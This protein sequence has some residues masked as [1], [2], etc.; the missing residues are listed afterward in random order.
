MLGVSLMGS[1]AVASTPVREGVP[2]NRTAWDILVNSSQRAYWDTAADSAV[3]EA[4]YL[5]AQA[6]LQRVGEGGASAS[7]MDHIAAALERMGFERTTEES[8]KAASE[9]A[10][11]AAAAATLP[12]REQ[13]TSF[14]WI[15]VSVGRSI[16][17]RPYAEFAKDGM[18]RRIHAGERLDGW[19]ISI[20]SNGAVSAT[21]G[22][23]TV[24]L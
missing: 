23:R 2:E 4:R 8:R 10:A 6:A 12:T 1:G 18:M 17:G 20:S 3:A 15:R 9:R 21:R 13:S 19:T 11:A 7:N 16:D 22:G 24:T 5:E 14:D